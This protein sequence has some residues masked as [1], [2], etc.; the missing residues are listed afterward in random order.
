MAALSSTKYKETGW[1]KEEKPTEGMRNQ[2]YMVEFTKK[3]SSYPWR[4]SI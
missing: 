2:I 3:L 4:V 1:R